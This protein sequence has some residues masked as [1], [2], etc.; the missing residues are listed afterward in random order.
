MSRIEH[1]DLEPQHAFLSVDL[2][3]RAIDD[4]EGGKNSF[5]HVTDLS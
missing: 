3:D 2:G 4:L 5:F 1:I